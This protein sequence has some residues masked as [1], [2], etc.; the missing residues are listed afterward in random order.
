MPIN[1]NFKKGKCWSCEYFCGKRDYKRGVFLGDSVYTD[2]KGICLTS[3]AINITMKFM[4]T[5]GVLDIKSGVFCG[6]P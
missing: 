3:E 6:L 1:N 5:D 2:D 4:K